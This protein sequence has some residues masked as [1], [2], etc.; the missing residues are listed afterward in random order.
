[1]TDGVPTHGDPE[2]VPGKRSLRA[3]LA[4]LA[5]SLVLKLGI[6]G[7]VTSSDPARFFTNDSYSYHRSARALLSDGAF[8]VSPERPDV[9]QTERTPGYPVLLAAVYAVFGANPAAA[10]AVQ[11]L[12]SLATIV[13]V[14]R[15]AGELG[16]EQMGGEQLGG[17]TG[18]W[19]AAFMAFD[20]ASFSHSLLLLTE[21]F[22]AFLICCMLYC[23]ARFDAAIPLGLRAGAGWALALGLYLALAT[24]VR[25]ITYYL[26]LPLGGWVLIVAGAR[27]RDWKRAAASLLLF[28]LPY[29]ALI[30][31][32]QLRNQARTGSAEFSSIAGKDL[33]FY[34]GAAVVAR[35]DGISLEAARRQ[36]GEHRYD[37]LHPETKDWSEAELS[38]R[39]KQEGLELMSSHPGITAGI[40]AQGLASI[41]LATGEHTVMR[42]VGMEVPATSPL[43]DLLRLSPADYWRAWPGARPFQWAAFAAG[44][45]FLGLLYSGAGAWLLDRLRRREI[46]LL[47]LCFWGMLLY[48]IVVPSGPQGY[49]RFR[50]P[51]MPILSLYAAA[52]LGLVLRWLARYR[53]HRKAVPG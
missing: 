32:W 43:G 27:L 8:A 38:S 23:A 49:E 33:L 52:G 7:I 41:L 50:V 10:I 5:M 29:L 17:M 18:I 53:D 25:P 9:P 6:W 34:R 3:L 12:I 26:V 22:F 47:D 35:R 1:M 37:E 19:A 15:L 11:I 14:T 4:L 24:H 40:H 20:L 45:V 28:V 21:T 36:L 39:W 44:F 46:S 13:F 48:L 2:R 51:A 42:L 16:S 30:G 31:G